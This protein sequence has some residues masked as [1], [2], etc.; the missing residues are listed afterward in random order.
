MKQEFITRRGLLLC[1]I[2]FACTSLHATDYFVSPS[3]SDANGTGSITTPWKTITFAMEKVF[4]G[5]ILYLRAGEYH[6]QFVSVRSG[7]P[8]A[9]ITIASYN[10]EV[11]F[12]DGTG[13]TTGN[14]GCLVSHSHMKFRGFTVRNWL[15]DGMTF[16][17]CEFIELKK[18]KVTAVTGGISLK[19]TVHDFVLDSCIMYD[20]YG[21]AG[22]LG[23]DA[24][25]EGATDRIYNGLITNCKAY[26]TAGAFDN[27]DGFALGHDGVSDITFYNCE[28]Y[29]I[30]DGFDISGA[31][32]VLERCS[33]HNSSYGGGYKLW[34]DSVTLINCIGYNNSTNVELDFD[35][36]T[37]KGVKARLINC[38]FFGCPNANIYIEN[39]GGGST[40]EM[41]NCILAG[42]DNT[43][44]TFDG[45]SIRCY[46]GDYNLFHMNNQ[47]RAVSTSQYDFSLTQMQNNEWAAFSGQDAHSR[48]VF[49]ANDLFKDTAVAKPDL[50]LKA[51][52]VAIDNGTS[53]PNVPSVDFDNLPRG[54]GK[55]DIGAYEY[56]P[57]TLID[58]ERDAGS[59]N[60]MV[61]AQNY[62]NPFRSST[63]IHYVLPE[64]STIRL[65][66]TNA[67]G[68]EIALIESGPRDAGSYDMKWSMTN[69]QFIPGVYFLRLVANNANDVIDQQTKSMI[70]LK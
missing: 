45:D 58:R 43:G 53:V 62:P 24:T 19:N 59:G 9:P 4:P 20:Y 50:H 63:T 8:A 47:E 2:L 48:V 15:H 67:L 21:G 57:K 5:D 52:A 32:I 51:G 34:R 11:V 35:F 14:N 61:L 26:L 39:T 10:D 17:N 7:T 12:I 55:V 16:S 60:G 70:S 36:P 31:G 68:Q 44:L 37:N 49:D 6:E 40:L 27:C 22:G 28:T 30:G 54:D 33:A 56:S 42:G 1:F 66:V 23:F 69:S 18:I 3:G 25:P 13:V 65:W 64:R 41:Y 29:G 46:R 38:T